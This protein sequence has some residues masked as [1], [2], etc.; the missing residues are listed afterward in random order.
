MKSFVAGLFLITSCLLPAAPIAIEDFVIDYCIDCHDSAEEKGGLNLEDLKIDPNDPKEFSI[1][2]MVHDRVEAGEMPPKK[3]DQP[4]AEEKEAA[5]NKETKANILAISSVVIFH[6]DSIKEL[7]DNIRQDSELEDIKIMIGGRAFD[8]TPEIVETMKADE[9]LTN[10][11]DAV[12]KARE[13]YE[14]D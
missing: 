1:W 9:Y 2:Q 12:T 7:I 14:R 6:L 4:G 13:W 11:D 8:T 5:L 10:A 3:K